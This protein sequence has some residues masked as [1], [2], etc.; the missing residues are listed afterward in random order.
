MV[1]TVRAPAATSTVSKKPAWAFFQ[2]KFVPITDAH[3][4]I[5]SQV[6]NYGI[7]AFGGVRAY[8]N[9]DRQQLYV[10][11]IDDPATGKLLSEKR[12]PETMVVNTGANP[13]LSVCTHRIRRG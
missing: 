2:N 9:A 10:F 3:V 5:M 6:V 7:G 13:F 8:W 4:S 12:N 11:R 1:Q